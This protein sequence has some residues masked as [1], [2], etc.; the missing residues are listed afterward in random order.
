MEILTWLNKWMRE[1]RAERYPARG[2]VAYYWGAGA[3]QAH[4][5]RDI[6]ATGAYFY[7]T[8][9]WQ[10]GTVITGTFRAADR[11]ESTEASVLSISFRIVRND[12]QG[13]GI[14]FLPQT[15]EELL[16][17]KRFVERAPAIAGGMMD[18]RS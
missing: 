17:L 10:T 3:P 1:E 12:P 14:S 6:S 16:N 2:I 15:K 11:P 7:D 13:V 5:L 8:D 4:P 18:Q 9:K